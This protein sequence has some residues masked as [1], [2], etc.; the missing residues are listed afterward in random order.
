MSFQSQ[1]SFIAP[2][3]FLTH[4][5]PGYRIT[6][7]IDP[8]R[9]TYADLEKYIENLE[10]MKLHALTSD[11]PIPEVDDRYRVK[12]YIYCPPCA[13]QVAAALDIC[14][15]R[16]KEDF[17]DFYV[18]IDHRLMT[19]CSASVSRIEGLISVIEHLKEKEK[20]LQS[21]YNSEVPKLKAIDREWLE[22]RID[23]YAEEDSLEMLSPEKQLAR[24]AKLHKE[25]DSC[26]AII[27]LGEADYC[28]P[29]M[30]S[31][32]FPPSE[33]GRLKETR[34]FRAQQECR[35]QQEYDQPANRWSWKI[36]Y[37]GTYSPRPPLPPRRPP[38]V[39][40]DDNTNMQAMESA[41]HSTKRPRS[42]ISDEAGC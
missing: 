4:S 14:C 11:L 41:Q 3:S 7:Y 24:I 20:I 31:P 13:C 25:E 28:I 32:P 2:G 37:M 16:D 10:A 33:S 1:Y 19:T 8:S 17:V 12:V 29:L 27:L 26:A 42:S 35:A 34:L 9:F 38:P 39:K 15:Y 40:P 5:A 21:F 30:G 23:D 22:R 6:K 18:R 36:D